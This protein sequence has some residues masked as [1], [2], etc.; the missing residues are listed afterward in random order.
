MGGGRGCRSRASEADVSPPRQMRQIADMER[1]RIH[2]CHGR[3]SQY[4]RP[5][6]RKDSPRAQGQFREMAQRSSYSRRLSR[7]RRFGAWL[8]GRYRRR[9]HADAASSRSKVRP[10]C[11]LRSL[12]T[13]E[14]RAA[15]RSLQATGSRECAPDDR[16][17]E[18]VRATARG[19]MN[20]FRLRSLELPRK[21]VDIVPRND[22][23]TIATGFATGLIV[24]PDRP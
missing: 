7:L 1:M 15:H 8:D 11:Q 21:V 20:C 12:R 18:T 4:P 14:L 9:G 3:T 13:S 2:P 17:R 22:G 10:G 6:R 19:R 24:R 16:L 23:A 5:S